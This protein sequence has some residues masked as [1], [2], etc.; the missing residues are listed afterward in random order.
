MYVCTITLSVSSE[1]LC[2]RIFIECTVFITSYNINRR[3]SLLATVFINRNDHIVNT[4]VTCEIDRSDTVSVIELGVTHYTLNS[5]LIKINNLNTRAALIV[6]NVHTVWI[7]RIELHF[8]ISSK[9]CTSA[10][11]TVIP[12]L[13]IVLI[14]IT[15]ETTNDHLT[16]IFKLFCCSCRLCTSGLITDSNLNLTRES[17]LRNE[18]I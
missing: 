3:T 5:L 11:R 15:A 6:S 10:E 18:N 8:T 2:V 4:V 17:S 7:L 14:T 16:F 12:S 13:I 9:T 1:Q